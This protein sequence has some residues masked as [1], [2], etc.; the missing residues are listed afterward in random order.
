MSREKGCERD[1]KTKPD[2]EAVTSMVLVF[3]LCEVLLV[4]WLPLDCIPAAASA[5][6]L[7]AATIALASASWKTA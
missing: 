2:I 5:S 6:A 1:P 7:A 4:Y 3:E